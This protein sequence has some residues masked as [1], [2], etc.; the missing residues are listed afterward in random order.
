ML[1]QTKLF[2]Y[3][4]LRRLTLAFGLLLNNKPNE[5]IRI[6]PLM[7]P[8]SIAT[9]VT[10]N[11]ADALPSFPYSLVLRLPS[12]ESQKSTY[13]FLLISLPFRGGLHRRQKLF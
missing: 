12:A 6:I 3:Y 2:V 13:L 7:K 1:F 8:H 5:K 10:S 9:I 4:R 11:E